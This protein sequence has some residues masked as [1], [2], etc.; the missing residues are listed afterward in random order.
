M[1]RSASI[2]Q[3][4]KSKIGNEPDWIVR[5]T[6]VCFTHR[7]LQAYHLDRYTL[8]LTDCVWMVPGTWEN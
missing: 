3:V 1:S 4:W 5:G 7:N 8:G 6:T 2:Y